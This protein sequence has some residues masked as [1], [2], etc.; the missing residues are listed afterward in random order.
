MEEIIE[1]KYADNG[2]IMNYPDSDY[3]CVYKTETEEERQEAVRELGSALWYDTV[4]NENEDLN[5]QIQK[6]CEANNCI[7][8]GMRLTIKIEPIYKQRK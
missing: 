2:I 6:H 3:L 4:E 8:E 7:C 1:I 5:E